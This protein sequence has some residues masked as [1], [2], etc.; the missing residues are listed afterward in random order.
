MCPLLVPDIFVSM[1]VQLALVS[2]ACNVLV[3]TGVRG[4][5]HLQLIQ[6]QA[7]VVPSWSCVFMLHTESESHRATAAM[8]N[9]DITS[10]ICVSG[11]SPVSALVWTNVSDSL[12][13]NLSLTLWSLYNYRLYLQQPTFL[14]FTGPGSGRVPWAGWLVVVTSVE[15]NRTRPLYSCTV[16]G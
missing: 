8:V 3:S 7:S 11:W 13:T 5:Y 9:T 1:L 14:A 12:R 16:T 6:Q 15:A 10:H 2:A 4:P